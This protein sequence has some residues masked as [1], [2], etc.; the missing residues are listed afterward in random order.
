MSLPRTLAF[1]V[2]ALALG[3]AS[4][5]EQHPAYGSA[6]PLPDLI[7]NTG[8]APNNAHAM[9][10]HYVVLASLDGSATTPRSMGATHLQ[11]LARDG[12]VLLTECCHHI[13]R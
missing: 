8:G 10:Q 12:H 6:K 7:V 9:K 3:C 4:S 13:R 1:A 5:Q 2:F 11:Q